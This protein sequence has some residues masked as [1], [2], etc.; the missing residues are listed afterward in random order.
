MEVAVISQSMS[1]LCRSRLRDKESS[2]V[3]L[4]SSFHHRRSPQDRKGRRTA[5]ANQAPGIPD[6]S[7]ILCIEVGLSTIPSPTKFP[8]D[9]LNKKFRPFDFG[10]FQEGS[11]Q[12]LPLRAVST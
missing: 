9:M 11:S 4:K 12:E 6:P 3:L 8:V 10:K 5:K 7:G 2:S 1:Q